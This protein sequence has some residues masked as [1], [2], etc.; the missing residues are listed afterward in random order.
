MTPVQLFETDPI[1][2]RNLVR[3]YPEKSVECVRSVGFRDIIINT[4]V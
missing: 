4:V 2:Q 3:N 1:R